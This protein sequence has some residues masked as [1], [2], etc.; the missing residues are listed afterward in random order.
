[1][2][3]R[4]VSCRQASFIWLVAI[5][6]HG[7]LCLLHGILKVSGREGT[8]SCG[9]C[10]LVQCLD[11]AVVGSA[12]QQTRKD[13][14]GR[15]FIAQFDKPIDISPHLFINFIIYQRH[16]AQIHA[17]MSQHGLQGQGQNRQSNIACHSCL[18]LPLIPTLLHLLRAHT[19]E[20]LIRR[21]LGCPSSSHQ[22]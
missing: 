12:R 20:V 14:C 2:Q 22:P 7:I 11:Q 10:V 4:P 13:S 1:M 18:L 5:K 6:M 19:Q 3:R 9:M 8:K 16:C 21:N 15:G 17:L